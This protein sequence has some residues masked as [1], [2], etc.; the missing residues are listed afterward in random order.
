M[1]EGEGQRLW[2]LYAQVMVLTRED[3]EQV[4]K[5]SGRPACRT[6]GGSATID[7]VTGWRLGSGAC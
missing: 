2:S 1:M 4:K 6:D 5:E 3:T 7:R